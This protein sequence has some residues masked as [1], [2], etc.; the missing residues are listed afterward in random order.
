[1]A[2]ILS[3][4]FENE[5]H[6]PRGIQVLAINRPCILCCILDWTEV[7]LDACQITQRGRLGADA[8]QTC[9]KVLVQLAPR[10]Q[11]KA[12]QEWVPDRTGPA[13]LALS[14]GRLLLLLLPF[15]PRLCPDQA[16]HRL[17]ETLLIIRRLM[18]HMALPCTLLLLLQPWLPWVHRRPPWAVAAD[19]WVDSWEPSSKAWRSELDRLLPTEQ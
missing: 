7:P 8:G 2:T 6:R 3:G 17:L 4:N 5:C 14:P 11:Q 12:K 10:K 19:S 13:S 9:I 16:P 15:R 1:M 18:L